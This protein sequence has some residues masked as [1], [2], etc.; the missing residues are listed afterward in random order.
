[1]KY[2]I[3]FLIVLSSC[4]G[5][6]KAEQQTDKALDKY[7]KIVA[8]IARDAFP[9]DSIGT[10]STAFKESQAEL[11]KLFKYYDSVVN[12]GQFTKE[13]LEQLRDSLQ[14]EIDDSVF[15]CNDLIEKLYDECN[16]GTQE[17][18]ELKKTIKQLKEQVKNIKPIKEIQVDQAQVYLIRDSFNV[19]HEKMLNYKAKYEAEQA[20]RKELQARIKGKVM[21]P[22]WVFPLLGAAAIFIFRNK[23]KS[24]IM[25]RVIP[26]LLV[27]SLFMLSSC[28]KWADGSKGNVWMEGKWLIFWLPLLGSLWFFYLCWKGSK[29]EW[30]YYDQTRSGRP[31]VKLGD[32]TPFRKVQWFPYAVG[33]LLAAIGIWLGVTLTEK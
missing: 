13:R 10:D 21:I 29:S 3:L 18:T 14:H 27:C 17:N 9:C 23:L 8:K 4:Y 1:M 28:A 16:K 26:I 32:K 24:L 20:L 22:W 7:P 15:N 25:K 30:G 31:W 12:A 6:K 5:P 11:Q 33:L 2:I 19:E